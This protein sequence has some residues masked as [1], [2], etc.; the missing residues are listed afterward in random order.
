MATLKST[1][2]G[3]SITDE[4]RSRIAATTI[5]LPV[6]RLD[7]QQKQQ[8]ATTSTPSRHQPLETLGEETA[9]VNEVLTGKPAVRLSIFSSPTSPS[10]CQTGDTSI[11][12]LES[13]AGE[14]DIQLHITFFLVFKG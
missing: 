3:A 14:L 4:E 12:P 10:I 8:F 13:T 7:R 2:R 1:V 6:P 11:A 9:E 5:W